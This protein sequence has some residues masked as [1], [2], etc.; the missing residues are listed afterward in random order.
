[1]TRCSKSAASPVRRETPSLRCSRPWRRQTAWATP[2]WCALLCPGRPG[3]GHRLLRR[4]RGGNTWRLS[5]APPR[6]TP[7]SSTSISWARR[8]R[9]TPSATGRT[10]SSPASW[11]MS[12][13]P[14]STR[15]T[16]S[17]SIP[18]AP[19]S[20]RTKLTMVN[21]TAA[22]RP[23]AQGEGPCQHPVCGLQRRGLHHR[24]QPP[25]PSRTVPYI[26]R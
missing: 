25:L 23:R 2:C 3:H 8:S 17:R 21:Y 26:S 12:S 22:S 14:A 13:A 5:T 11:S 7:C 18:P 20:G 16:P 19:I 6:S 24:G 4:G 1:M 9:S 10:S 15:A